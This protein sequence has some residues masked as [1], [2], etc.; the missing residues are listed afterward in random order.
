LGFQWSNRS[1]SGSQALLWQHQ[2][3]LTKSPELKQQLI[4]Y[5]LED[6]EALECVVNTIIQ[7]NQS[8]ENPEISVDDNVVRAESLMQGY[9]YGE[10]RFSIPEMEYVNKAAYW[11][12]QRD[13]I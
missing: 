10:R 12:Y 11:D 2:W 13:Q 5:N 3:E 9:P 7:L 1:A 4:T 8:H 6:C